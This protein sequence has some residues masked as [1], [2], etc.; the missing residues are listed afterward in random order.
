MLS[1]L[2]DAAGICWCSGN[3]RHHRGFGCYHNHLR[4][5]RG[6]FLIRQQRQQIPLVHQIQEVRFVQFCILIDGLIVV[7]NQV[8]GRAI[9]EPAR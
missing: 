7:N 2:P 9:V 1:F 4:G 5:R 8:E 6:Q 3:N